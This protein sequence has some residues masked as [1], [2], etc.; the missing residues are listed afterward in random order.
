MPSLQLRLPPGFFPEI[1]NDRNVEDEGDNNDEPH[2]HHKIDVFEERRESV[3][4]AVADASQ[5]KGRNGSKNRI[6]HFFYF[7]MVKKV[8]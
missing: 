8:I 4:V 6:H 7:S 1:Q 3:V 2:D 5:E